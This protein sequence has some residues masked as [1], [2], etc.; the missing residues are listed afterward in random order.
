[1]VDEFFP[2]EMPIRTIEYDR[3]GV[4]TE[5]LSKTAQLKDALTVIK[6]FERLQASINPGY[7]G[8]IRELLLPC[9]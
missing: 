9:M 8:K 6:I 3:N 4:K 7:K 2:E 5:K 1:M